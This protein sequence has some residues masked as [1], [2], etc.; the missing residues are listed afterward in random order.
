MTHLNPL[1]FRGRGW[2][3]IPLARGWCPTDSS[4]HKLKCPT[5]RKAI[6]WEGNP[7]RPFCSEHCRNVDLGRWL[8]E[9]IRV[10]HEAGDAP[11][12][13]PPDGVGRS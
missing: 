8:G 2:Y 5:C 3:T 7:Y 10:R 11:D 12:S 13:P 9:E 6:A 1:R 4:V